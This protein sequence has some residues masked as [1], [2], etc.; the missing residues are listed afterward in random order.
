MPNNDI[1]AGISGFWDQRNLKRWLTPKALNQELNI[2]N[3]Q[4][5]T[6]ADLKTC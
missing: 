1:Q 2:L 4:R 3:I 5:Y 6:N